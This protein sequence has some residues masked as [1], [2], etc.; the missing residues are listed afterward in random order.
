[1]VAGIA[2]HQTNGAG[3][4]SPVDG[5]ASPVDGTASRADG[6]VNPADGTANPADGVAGQ[7]Q[8]RNR[9]GLLILAFRQSLLHRL[10]LALQQKSPRQIRL[11]Y[12]H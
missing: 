7:S 12:Q 3:T 9:L 1:M 8:L 6:I 5:T 10:L 11:Q 4:A 2:S